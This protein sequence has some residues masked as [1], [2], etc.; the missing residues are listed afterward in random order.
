MLSSLL[1]PLLIAILVFVTSALADNRPTGQSGDQASSVIQYKEFLAG[2]DPADPNSIE[3]ALSQCHQSIAEC[4]Q[5]ESDLAFLAFRQFFYELIENLN[6]RLWDEQSN[7]DDPNDLVKERIIEAMAPYRNWFG[8]FESEGN[9]SVFENEHFLLDTFYRYLSPP[10]H[11]FLVLRSIEMR[12]VF[13]EDA[14][15]R[16]DLI[17]IGRRCIQWED[18][19]QRY[20]DSPLIEDAREFHRIYLSSLLTGTGNSPILDAGETETKQEHHQ[21]VIFAYR[22]LMEK[23]PD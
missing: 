3:A 10:L 14:A 21:R 23:F 7:S 5:E 18:Y 1:S 9:F 22:Q 13:Q 8:L 15:L 11:R 16:V 17:E 4:S 12:E 2:L 19:L 6:K 20:P